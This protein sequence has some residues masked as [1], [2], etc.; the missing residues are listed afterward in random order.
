MKAWFRLLKARILLLFSAALVPLGLVPVLYFLA[1]VAWQLG[2][3]LD[4]GKW[5]ALPATLILSDYALRAEKA[6]AVVPFVPHFD[7]AWSTN[8]VV[9]LLLGKP[10]V[11]LA[12]ALLGCLIIALGVLG[13]L[14]Q[15]ERIRVLKQW[16]QDR[17]R[18]VQDYRSDTSRAA[19]DGRVEPFIGSGQ[20]ARHTDRRVA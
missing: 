4:T 5:V 9:L 19:P 1:L 17:V 14:R 16:K 3:R 8:E 7:T 12:P 18:R 10:H 2:A 11:G 13:V 15:K 20:V 6:A